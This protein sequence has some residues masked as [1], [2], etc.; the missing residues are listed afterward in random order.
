MGKY[1]KQFKKYAYKGVKAAG[2]IAKKRYFKGKGYKQP[3]MDNIINDV[4]M[5]KAM[6]NAEKHRQIYN[7]SSAN[8]IS[9]V[10]GNANGYWSGDV[11]PNVG[12]GTGVS[13]RVGGSIK[14]HSSHWDFQFVH[15]INTQAPVH[16]KIMLIKVN[17]V[18][19]SNV[20]NIVQTMF[21]NNPFIQSGTIWDYNSSRN[22]DQ[23]KNY[24]I[25]K[26]RIVSLAPDNYSGIPM[27]KNVKFGYKFKNHHC[28]WAGDTSTLT[29]GQVIMLMFADNG[30]ASPSTAC[31]IVNGV[32]VKTVL[33]G[34]DFQYIQ[35]HYYYDN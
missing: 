32:P 8:T 35:T 9:Q 15:Q 2:R 4:K 26:T 34:I 3:R 30:N 16:I 11:T 27:I 23:Y 19:Q 28:R 18:A 31:T 6:I 13:Q 24:T 29:E 14:W 12:Q 7:S 21:N 10:Y 5:L 20:S 1:Y 33:T 22:Q 17:G 25:L